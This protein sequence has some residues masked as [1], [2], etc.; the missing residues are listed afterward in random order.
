MGWADRRSG[1]FSTQDGYGLEQLS[2]VAERGYPDLLEIFIRQG[3]EERRVNVVV[4]ESR[5]VLLEAQISQPTE[6]IHGASQLFA[7]AS[8]E[9][10]AAASLSWQ[11]Q[12]MLSGRAGL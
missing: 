5:L 8:S 3:Q 11:S 1:L 9:K 12:I 4:A 2:A 7:Y 10:K 6:N